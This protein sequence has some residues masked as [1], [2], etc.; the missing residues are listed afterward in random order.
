MSNPAITDAVQKLKSYTL[1]T[2]KIVAVQIGCNLKLRPGASDSGKALENV[3][4]RV[5]HALPCGTFVTDMEDG[6]AIVYSP[7]GTYRVNLK[8]IS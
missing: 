6:S 5:N 4:V 1:P 3:P 7:E 2:G 8:A